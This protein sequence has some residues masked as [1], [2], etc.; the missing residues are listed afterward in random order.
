MGRTLVKEVFQGR[1]T[2]GVGDVGVEEV[3]SIV[4]MMVL[5]F[6]DGLEMGIDVH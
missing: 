6:A 5:G 3:T 4:A 1:E 2:I